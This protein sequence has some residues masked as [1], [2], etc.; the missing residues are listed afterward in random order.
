MSENLQDF[1]I[2]RDFFD[3]AFDATWII[4]ETGIIEYANL[5][6]SA[7]VGYQAEE[8]IGR[9]LSIILPADIAGHHDRYMSDY[10]RRDGESSVLG[11]ARRFE[12]VHASGER[13]PIE[14]KAFESESVRGRR[15]FGAVMIDIR[16]R[17]EA[18]QA[19]DRLLE[20]LS[21]LALTD[22]LTGL[23]NRRA[24]SDAL[25]REVA[26][27]KRHRRASS[28]AVLDLDDF[29]QVN[30]RFGHAAG[31]ALLKSV[32][33]ILANAL[34]GEDLV[35]R[36]GG[37][38]FGVLLP[39]DPANQAAEVIERIRTR[40]SE[41][42]IAVGNQHR[43]WVTLSAGVAEIDPN[44]PIAASLQSADRAMY[45]AKAEG[46]NRVVISN[47]AQN[48]DVVSQATA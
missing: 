1:G 43:L 13:I 41:S 10:L 35:A 24:F 16:E 29:K 19:Q 34:R 22:E 46:R 32:A 45:R 40:V 33:T 18:Q 38:E 20:R 48:P 44:R 26:S 39:N 27:M 17:L 6:A 14:L 28:V 3:H 31:D 15:R 12:I 25:E 23:A 5:A 30:D 37:E 21:A 4:G 47:Q 11:R 36:I 2:F 8:L 7:L 42:R 9:P